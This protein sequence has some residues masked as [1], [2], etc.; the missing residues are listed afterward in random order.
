MN[1]ILEILEGLW[2]THLYYKGIRVNLFGVHK[3]LK[4]KENSL[5]VTLSRM[6]KIGLIVNKHGTWRITS[7]G[8]EYFKFHNKPFR[9]FERPKGKKT[10]NLLVIF[11]IPEMMRRERY[12]FRSHLIKFGFEMVQKSVWV[13]PGPLP[14][15][16]VSYSKSIGLK[17]CIKTFKLSTK[18]K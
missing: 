10:K 14:S 6:N 11:D 8:K 16:F 1:I 13:G 5:R 12:W 4:K 17:D 2:N 15:E 7:A 18:S 3:P 9:N